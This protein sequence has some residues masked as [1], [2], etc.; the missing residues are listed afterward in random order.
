M[1]FNSKLSIKFG[2][3]KIIAATLFFGVGHVFAASIDASSSVGAQFKQLGVPVIGQFKK[4][5][6][7]V[8]L[9]MKQLTAAKASIDIDVSSF[10][11]GDAAYNQEVAKKEWFDAK[12]FPKATFQLSSVTQTAPNKYQA[13]GSLTIK[14]KS[15]VINFP[16]DIKQDGKRQ[17]IEGQV[18]IKRL[19]FSIGEGEWKDTSVVADEVLIK[20][21]IVTGAK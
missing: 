13:T 21:K 19:Q 18:P 14:N 11:L 20:F 12:T 16:V 1:Y 6:G 10:D 5:S 15:A 8:E 17:T 4:F 7:Q 9:D 3:K 2:L